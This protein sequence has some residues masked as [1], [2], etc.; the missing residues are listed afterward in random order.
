M[1]S[2]S[3]SPP[4]FTLKTSWGSSSTFQP[5]NCCSFKGWAPRSFQSSRAAFH[6]PSIGGRVGKQIHGPLICTH[7]H[8]TGRKI[9]HHANPIPVEPGH[10]FMIMPHE[11]VDSPKVGR[12]LDP[13]RKDARATA[14]IKNQDLL[15]CTGRRR[16]RRWQWWRRL[17]IYG[18][19][20]KRAAIL[21]AADDFLPPPPLLAID[22]RHWRPLT[23]PAPP[24]RWTRRGA[25]GYRS[26]HLVHATA[27]TF[28]P[29]LGMFAATAEA[30]RPAAQA[31]VSGL[32][33]PCPARTRPPEGVTS[34]CESGDLPSL[35]HFRLKI[36]ILTTNRA[37]HGNCLAS[38]WEAHWKSSDSGRCVRTRQACC[39]PSPAHLL[40]CFPF[41][42]V[43]GALLVVLLGG[44]RVRL[45]VGCIRPGGIGTGAL[46]WV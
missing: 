17:R 38:H 44:L 41:G 39:P 5:S 43:E 37:K 29:A 35:A 36:A 13:P 34:V 2:I 8:G 4:S 14:G 1:S 11:G 16:W 33:V 42:Q 3:T 30:G 45:L 15:S 18:G 12:V 46:G 6:C 40:L 25:E 10:M 26:P 23:G 27:S 31:E 32:R 20:N 21:A 24:G 7:C 9:C 19:G 22:I 28:H